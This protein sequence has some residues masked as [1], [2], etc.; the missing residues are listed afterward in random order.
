MTAPRPVGALRHRLTLERATTD[1]AGETV[2]SAV[3]TLFAAITPVSAGEDI[4]GDAPTGRVGHRLEMR[5]R[6]DVTSRDRLRLGDRV[7]RIVAVH[8]LDERRR[9]LVVLAEEE[10]R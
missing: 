4:A 8:D 6:A 5:W 1:A 3:D 10:G 9:R 7:F 2:W